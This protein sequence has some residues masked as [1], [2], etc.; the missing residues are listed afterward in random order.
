MKRFAVCLALFA[1]ASCAHVPFFK[2]TPPQPA[3]ATPPPPAKVTA[4]RSSV[5]A[6]A[7]DLTFDA[8]GRN[9][10]LRSLR[11][12]AVVL[13]IAEDARSGTF[14]KQ[15]KELG[16]IYQEFAGKGVIFIAALK[17]DNGPVRSNIPFVIAV[18]GPGVAAKYHVTEKFQIAIIG[19]D[20]NID[21]QTD[22]VLPGGR[23]RDVIQ[24]SFV[25]QETARRH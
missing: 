20:G 4:R 18:D 14:K 25:V 19:P 21:Y 23:V 22:K 10:T 1:F 5:V 13:V 11:G 8:P 2:R 17:H 12:Q 7:P 16:P 15:L 24:N 6:P 3:P 9:R